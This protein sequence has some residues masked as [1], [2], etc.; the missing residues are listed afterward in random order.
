MSLPGIRH[1]ADAD[2]LRTL[3]VGAGEAGRTLAKALRRSPNYGLVPIGFLDDAHAL[4]R[5]MGLPV[6]RPIEALAEVAR[7]QRADACVV[8][9]PSLPPRRLAKIVDTARA[10]G[11]HVR[12]LP[13]FLAAV[14]RDARLSDLRQLRVESLLGRREVHVV[15]HKAATLIS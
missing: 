15:S 10:G 7:T 8:A 14:E 9:I 3:I 13:S 2:G 6:Y 12:Y 11:L 5:T 4:T 1:T